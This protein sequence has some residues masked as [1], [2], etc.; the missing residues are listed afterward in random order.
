[1]KFKVVVNLYNELHKLFI[2]NYM[3]YLLL[4]IFS[5]FLAI[6]PRS[7]ALYL[8]KF[9]GLIIY[10]LLPIRKKVAFINGIKDQH[11]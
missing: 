5:A 9:F 3:L 8:G 1:M 10:F 11:M 2:V 4:N 6:L 7:I